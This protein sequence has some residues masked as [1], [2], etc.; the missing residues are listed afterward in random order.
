MI[1]AMACGTPVIAFRGGSVAE[2]VDDGVTGFV[3]E[4][5][6]EAVEALDRI[7]SIDRK[8]CRARFEQRF[9]ARRMCEDYLEAYEQGIWEKKRAARG[10]RGLSLT[11]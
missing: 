7:P 10:K 5:I 6:E 4:S 9:S 3:V 1:E 2:I 8:E 11:F